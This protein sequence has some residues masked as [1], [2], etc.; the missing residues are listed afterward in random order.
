M[1]FTNCGKRK[2]LNGNELAMFADKARN[3]ALDVQSFCLTIAY[4]G[5]RI[6]EAL[7]L[8]PENIDF[9]AQAL[10]VKCLKK[11]GK[12]V[13]RGIPLPVAL[14]DILRKQALQVDEST[15]RLWPWSRMTG[16]RRIREVMESAGIVGDHASPKGLRHGFA[17][18]AIQA[19]VPLTMVQRW[20]GHADIKTTAIYTSAMGA[21]ERSLAARMWR[22]EVDGQTAP[23]AS[24]A[25]APASISARPEPPSPPAR[26][27]TYGTGM[28][29][30]VQ[31]RPAADAAG[32][33][34]QASRKQGLSADRASKKTLLNHLRDCALVQFWLNCNSKKAINS[35]T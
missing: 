26:A 3:L 8:T 7:A 16:Y 30:R 21:E 14:L 22:E 13:Y 31:Y 9:E 34:S 23:Q 5:C 10:I 15:Q 35:H 19:N 18:Q 17:V 11:R 12:I 4:T 25:A 28:R 32:N 1:I 2:Y 24:T 20:L 6:S 27:R 29:Y 33:P